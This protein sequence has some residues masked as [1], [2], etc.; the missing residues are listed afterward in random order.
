MRRDKKVLFLKINK[1]R[2]VCRD[3]AE[4]NYG[5]PQAPQLVYN[6]GRKIICADRREHPEH[7]FC[8]VVCPVKKQAREQKQNPLKAK[9]FPKRVINYSKGG[10]TNPKPKRYDRKIISDEF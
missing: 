7:K 10:E 5:S 3:D 9:L 1:E 6:K 2:N 4:N 8:R